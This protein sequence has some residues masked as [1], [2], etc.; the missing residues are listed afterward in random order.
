MEYEANTDKSRKIFF[1]I[2]CEDE[3]ALGGVYPTSSSYIA[4]KLGL[5]VSTVKYYCQKLR[6]AGLIEACFSGGQREDGSPFCFKG[7]QVTEAGKGTDLYKEASIA[8]QEA[9]ERFWKE[10]LSSFTT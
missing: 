1:T 3:D 7:Y 2:A 9:F 10:Y 6:R 8:Q 4:E 5:P